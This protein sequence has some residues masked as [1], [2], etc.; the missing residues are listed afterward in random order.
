MEE[1]DR[2]P[3]ELY[4]GTRLQA[5]LD[6]AAATPEDLTP[7]ERD[8]LTE[9]AD[10]ADRQLAEQ[11]ARADREARGRR[12]ARL[13]AGLL[14]VTLAFAASAGGYAVTQQRKAARAAVTAD[15]G[16]LGA[17]ARAGGDY[18]RSLLLAA[19]AVKLDPSPETE[20]DLFATLLRGDAV[21]ATMRAPHTVQATTFTP[22]GSSI[23]A[24]TS[25]GEVEQWPAHG[26]RAQRSSSSA[27]RQSR[28]RWPGTAASS[29]AFVGRA[30]RPAQS[31]R[32]STPATA[33]CSTRCRTMSMCAG[34]CR[35]TDG[36]RSSRSRAI[37]SIDR[38]TC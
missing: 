36:L 23:L 8:F 13:V 15:A 2:D 31:G 6:L 4:H 33:R 12:R 1:A 32:W 29:S 14:A 28:S 5:A 27:R 18:D 9:S 25:A 20:S 24:V 10:E 37:S 35:R 7:L 17:L 22:D 38:R 26:G 3:A 21:L 11:R 19:Q 30:T 16:R 34:P